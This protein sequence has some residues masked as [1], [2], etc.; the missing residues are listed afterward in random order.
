ML[1]VA[2]CRQKQK[3]FHTTTVV[4][5]GCEWECSRVKEATL[6]LMDNLCTGLA[7][8]VPVI[9]LMEISPQHHS[10]VLGKGNINLKIIMQVRWILFGN[11]FL[12]LCGLLALDSLDS[13]PAFPAHQHRDN[14]P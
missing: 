3:N 10:T 14:L 9:M 8:S 2:R 4:V 12:A 7:G 5:K 1:S 11:L 13:D 6:L